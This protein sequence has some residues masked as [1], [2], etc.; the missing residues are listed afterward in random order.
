VD[1]ERSRFALTGNRESAG[2]VS[3]GEQQRMAA[4]ENGRKATTVET[5]RGYR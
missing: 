3:F 4:G 1:L 2:V 5:Q